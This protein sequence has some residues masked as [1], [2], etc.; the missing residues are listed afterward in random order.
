MTSINAGGAFYR[1]Q[2]EMTNNSDRLSQNM[3]RLASGKQ[4]I[5]PG[6]RT[7]STAVAFAM[8]AESASL[9]VGMMNGTEALQSIEMVTNDLAQLN[10]IVVRLEEIHALGSNAFVT[11][12]DRSALTAEA[13]NLLAEMTRISGDATWKGNSI[14]KTSATDTTTNTMSFGRNAASIDIVLDTFTIPEVALGFNTVGDSIYGD[15]DISPGASAAG[16]AYASLTTAPQAVV[17]QTVADTKPND[18][19]AQSALAVDGAVFYE[20]LTKAGQDKFNTTGTVDTNGFTLSVKA[21]AV[22][23]A[24]VVAAVDFDAGD[25]AT[26]V[27]GVNDIAR[28]LLMTDA[29]DNTNASF[30]IVGTDT[31]GDVISEVLAGGNGTTTQSVNMYK[32]I[33]SIT[34]TGGDAAGTSTAFG[35][36]ADDNTQLNL[37][38]DLASNGTVTNDAGRNVRI[39]SQGDESTVKF[40]VTGTDRSGNVLTEEIMGGIS[41]VAGIAASAVA[42]AVGGTVALTS[43][44]V[45]NDIPKS[46]MMTQTAHDQTGVKFTI[47]GT[48]ADGGALTE[49]IDGLGAGGGI[50]TTEAL[51]KTITSITNAGVV[52]PS[53]GTAAAKVEF[54]TVGAAT[55]SQFFKTITSVITDKAPLGTIEVGVGPTIGGPGPVE[56]AGSDIGSGSA[57]SALAL[58]ALKTVVDNMNINAGTLFNKVSNTMSHMGSLNAGYQLDLASKMDVDFAGET[59]ELAKGQILAQAGT[60]MLAQANAQRQGM[61]AL[62]QS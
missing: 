14:I 7:A 50:S 41:V 17:A 21:E 59:A 20:H 37:S 30:T 16:T 34:N 26:I 3:Q 45:T 55:G 52:S 56:L 38:G 12:E 1:V 22:A 13:D 2:N 60:A 8:K 32:T 46:V 51:F 11:T 19:T 53:A 42:P 49:T 40:T 57:E 47:V 39:T 9:K 61:L 10:D 15:I 44:T 28:Q 35:T 23:A 25:V 58:L 24:G 31:N 4:N 62:L 36:S 33:T 5:A 43:G 54:G 18:K 27:D 48:G 6:D 29:G